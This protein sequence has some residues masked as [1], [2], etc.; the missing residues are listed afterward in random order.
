MSERLTSRAWPRTL[1]GRS[2]L[3]LFAAV[4]ISNGIGLAAYLGERRSL[5]ITARERAIAERVADA[6]RLIEAAASADRPKLLRSLRGAGLRLQWSDQPLPG[7]VDP[8]GDRVRSLRAV[9]IEELGVDKGDGLRLRLGRPGDAAEGG[10]RSVKGPWPPGWSGRGGEH[11]PFPRA[12]DKATF[13]VLFGGLRLGDGSWLNFAAPLTPQTPSWTSSMLLLI[14]G[15]SLAAAAIAGFVVWR[16]SAPL[17]VFAAA[18]ERL[19]RDLDA[20]PLPERG[21]AEV[22]LAARAFNEMQARLQRMVRQRTQMLAAMSHDLRT[23]LTRLRL[24]AEL[25]DDPAQQ[26][27]TLADLDQIEDLIGTSLEFARD[28]FTGEAPAKLDLAALVRTICDEAADAGGR[29]RYHGPERA[30]FAARQMALRRALANLVD[31]AMRHGEEVDVALAVHGN[32]GSERAEILVEDDGPGLP[33]S[34]LGKVGEPFYRPD[35]SRSRDS[36]GAG[37][38]LAIVRAVAVAHGGGITLTN[39][40]G[41]GLRAA[42]SIASLPVPERSAKA[43]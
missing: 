15:T 34:E 14:A 28:A 21:P 1:V 33:E 30:P 10:E 26:Q 16:A 40:D 31:N 13:A 24:R 17:S 5:Q 7:E 18:S 37:L 32:G 43:S 9:F 42:L 3:V 20:P 35:A 39:R 2:I 41:G 29:I 4:L 36:G 38:G 12:S 25:M 11:G 19:G 8:S 27:K 23:P 22:T 6:A